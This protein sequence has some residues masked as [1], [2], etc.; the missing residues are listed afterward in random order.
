MIAVTLSSTRLDDV[1]PFFVE[2]EDITRYIDKKYSLPGK[3]VAIHKAVVL[4]TEFVRYVFI[5]EE[6]R[7]EFMND[8][9]IKHQIETVRLR[10]NNF[11]AHK[12][13]VT[14]ETE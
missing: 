9:I 1:I 10:F 11:H 8:E 14:F 3:L 5:S 7:S 13:E 4:K 12:F 6:T 2:D